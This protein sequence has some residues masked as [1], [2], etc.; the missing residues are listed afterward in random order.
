[1]I[2][3]PN[4][5]ILCSLKNTPKEGDYAITDDRTC[6]RFADGEW[7]QVKN[8]GLKINAYELGKQLCAQSPNLNDK[9]LFEARAMINNWAIS[10]KYYMLYGRDIHYFTLFHI[11]SNGDTSI[12]T[13][14]LDCLHTIGK[15]KSITVNDDN[16]IECWISYEGDGMVLYLFPYDEGVIECIR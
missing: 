12:G 9:Q 15:I 4:Y 10:N 8:E 2:Q 6:Y 5:K 1:M 11:N 3:V 16:V 14:V 7:R 13:E